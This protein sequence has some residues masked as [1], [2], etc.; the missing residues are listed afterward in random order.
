MAVYRIPADAHV[1]PVHLTVRNLERVLTLYRETLGLATLRKQGD[2]FVLGVR[3]GE[4][5][6]SRPL[7]LLTESPEAPSPPRRS[8]GLYHVAIRLP[9]RRALGDTLRRLSQM[10]YPLQGAANHHVS[11]ALYLADPEG[12]G[13][14]I[15]ADTPT[16]RW[17]DAAGRL[18]MDTAPLDVNGLLAEAG[19]DGEW[20]GL[21]EG[22]VVGHIHLRVSDI[23][24]TERFYRD[25]L[26]M[27]LMARYGDQAAFFSAGGYHHHIGANTW[28]SA[29]APPPPPGA[30]GLRYYTL[31]LPNG[32]ALDALAQRLVDAGLP[33]ERE[34]LRVALRDPSGN[35]LVLLSATSADL[36]RAAA[37]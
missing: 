31:V 6:T 24:Q 35:R 1:G 30:A 36:A 3:G 29:G 9:T 28:E 4:P 17:R 7:L 11:E 22:T 10:R 32:D 25:L 19:E 16:S 8:T 5:G 27:D 37:A 26:G 34:P 20:T 23:P 2:A 15:Y 13:L 18:Q 14:E 21:P 12:N 33:L